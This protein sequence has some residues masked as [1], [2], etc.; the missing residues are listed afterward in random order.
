MFGKKPPPPRP[1]AN[2][3]VQDLKGIGHD[4]VDDGDNWIPDPMKKGPLDSLDDDGLLEAVFA[5]DDE[6][7]TFMNYHD[8]DNYMV[9]GNHRMAE[10]LKRAADPLHKKIN[11][12]TPIFVKGFPKR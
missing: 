1:A 6:F 11:F 10:L 3:T 5:P 2:G 12:D 8:G 4:M 7:R 9:E